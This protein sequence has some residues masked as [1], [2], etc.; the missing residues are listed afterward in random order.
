MST[1]L[2]F[3]RFVKR[4]STSHATESESQPD[5]PG[6]RFTNGSLVERARAAQACLRRS[7]GLADARIWCEVDGGKIVLRGHVP[8]HSAKHAAR[9]AAEKVCGG[10]KIENRLGV[11]PYPLE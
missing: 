7:L 1:Q 4:S 10:C 3:S 6:D 9:A 11:V 5:A 8:T 2:M